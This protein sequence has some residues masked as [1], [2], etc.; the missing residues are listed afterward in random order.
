[1]ASIAGIVFACAALAFWL[2]VAWRSSDWGIDR[3]ARR[4]HDAGIPVQT[5]L[6]VYESM[7][8]E[9]QRRLIDDP[10]IEHLLP[11][12]Q[13][14]WRG[15]AQTGGA[16]AAYAG[17]MKKVAGAL[18]RSGVPLVAGTDAMGAPLI[19]PGSSLV[20]ELEV[21]TDCGLTPADAIRAATLAPAAF[22][23]KADEFGSIA[24]GKRADL[25]LVDHNPLDGIA[26][27]RQPAGVVTRGRWL[28]RDELDRM[29][30]AMKR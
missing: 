17:F 9:G 14:I 1:M 16:P 26:N 27:L 22:L 8:R 20:H 12:T 3:L 21:L 10:A 25:L 15:A 7:S 18:H 13:T 6:V 30:A 5:T 11:E 28:P 19:A 24:V 23:R 4:V 2:P 29:L